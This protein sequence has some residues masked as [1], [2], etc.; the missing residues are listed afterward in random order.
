M[1]S[2]PPIEMQIKSVW[3][4]LPE[5]ATKHKLLPLN[6]KIVDKM[7]LHHNKRPIT[8]QLLPSTTA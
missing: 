2:D 6:Q 3:R 7:M 1:F 4:G 8:K 5:D